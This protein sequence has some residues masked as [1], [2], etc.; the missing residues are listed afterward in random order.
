[1]IKLRGKTW[2]ADFYRADGTR[3]RKSL[4]TTDKKQA[5]I[6]EAKLVSEAPTSKAHGADSL[7]LEDAYDGAMKEQEAWRTSKSPRTLEGNW[8]H[9][10]EHFG[11]DRELSSISSKDVTSYI[12]KMQLCKLSG[13]T[14][15]QRLS[16]L[17]VLYKQ[18]EDWGHDIAKPRLT[19]QK[20][21]KGRQRRV[22][23]AEEARIIEL[24][25][26]G[27][28]PKHLEMA[29]L[30]PVLVDTGVRLSEALRIRDID[31]DFEQNAIV[32]WENKADHPRAVPMTQRVR[33]I[34]EAR[35]NL[36]SIF[37]KLSV[38]SADDCWEW[39]RA[40]M[41]L[42]NDKEFVIHALRHSTA[43]RLADAGV[44]AFRIQQ[45]MGH[46]TITTTQKYVHVSAAGLQ[47]LTGVLEAASTVT[48]SDG[49][50]S[51][52][53]EEEKVVTNSEESQAPGENNQLPAVETIGVPVVIDC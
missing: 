39:V 6:L 13:S 24:F 9:V 1:M 53:N 34:M 52:Q 38:D 35:K 19:R 30:V 23:P 51:A 40:K 8:K 46:K 32:I 16:I 42:E 25:K 50:T 3:V 2:W 49:H 20:V 28:K 10:S 48:K 18:A 14:I 17:S 15:N 4:G 43:S 36:S 7:T 26:L 5:Q 31:I 29:D 27:V 45:M 33:K 41:D 12:Q 37:G 11:K 47:R 44:D 22:S 21:N